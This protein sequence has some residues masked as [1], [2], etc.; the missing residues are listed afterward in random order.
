MKPKLQI[1]MY[2]LQMRIGRM[3][4]TARNKKRFK[5]KKLKKK[6]KIR[7]YSI[8]ALALALVIS[9]CIVTFAD[10]PTLSDKSIVTLLGVDLAGDEI[11]ITAQVIVPSSGAETQ[12]NK[13][14]VSARGSN[15]LAALN[16]ISVTEGRKVEFGQ[17]GLIVFG[18]EIVERGVLNEIKTLFSA[19]TVSSGVLVVTTNDTASEFIAMAA[20]LD[21]DTSENLARLLNRLNTTTEMPML[22]MLSFLNGEMGESGS[23]FMPIVNLRQQ[24]QSVQG[25]EAEAESEAEGGGGQN[26]G[27]DN[28]V[29]ESD[30]ASLN[31]AIVTKN[32]VKVGELTQTETQGLNFTLN[33]SKKGRYNIDEF[34][35]SDKQFESLYGHIRRKS[36]RT[37]T[38]FVDGKPKIVYNIDVRIQLDE[39]VSLLGLNRQD[40]RAIDA[41]IR[42]NF[43][44]KI[45]SEVESAILKSKE[46]DADFLNIKHRFFRTINRQMIQYDNGAGDFL[47]ELEYEIK[48]KVNLN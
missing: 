11:E 20:N 32:G 33:E 18:S 5:L 48:V 42:Q 1:T 44:N 6:T 39:D 40:R 22:C 21:E 10:M 37:R 45:K 28:P 7:I 31:T 15:L 30:I 2:K 25:E 36:V 35:H 16:S 24:D 26:G 34:T 17:C 27:K 41:V 14:V 13:E 47:S 23:S 38:S 19:N 9:Y 46:L 43:E 4:S 29:G 12:F 8:I 3:S